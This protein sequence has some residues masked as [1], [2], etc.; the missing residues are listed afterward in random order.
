MNN[1]TRQE[2]S[3]LCKQRALEYVEIGDYANA[4]NSLASDLEKHSATRGHPAVTLGYQLMLVGKLSGGE[5]MRN[6]IE[7]CH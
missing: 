6:F 1:L 3:A 2:Y 4:M 5:E 7:R